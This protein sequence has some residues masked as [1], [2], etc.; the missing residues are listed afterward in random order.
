[1]IEVRRAALVLLLV[2]LPVGLVIAQTKVYRG[3]TLTIQG[4][5]KDELGNGV[6]GATVE[7]RDGTTVLASTTSGTGGSFT[8]TW[9]V[10]A[11]YPLGPKTLTVYV[12]E[13]PSIYVE[14]SSTSVSIEVWDLASIQ[15]QGPSRIH[16]GE[17][18]TVSGQAGCSS[19]TV[20]LYCGGSQV[21]SCSIG[22]DGSF[23]I[24]FT[25]PMSWERG[26][27]TL[28]LTGSGGQYVELQGAELETE[29]WIRPNIE[30]TS[31]S[32]G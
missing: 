32:G 19:G 3:S 21:G 17:E 27:K 16:R 29:L 24:T 15:A 13:Q 9:N 23:S 12:P 20:Q 26:P 10:P 25:V 28:T 8:L 1:V 31:V 11:G 22:S 5:V 2:L 30:I 4:V 6:A 14:A 18:V 7:L